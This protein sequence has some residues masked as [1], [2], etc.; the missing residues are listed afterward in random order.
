MS[1]RESPS[2]TSERG[3]GEQRRA[4]CR[5]HRSHFCPCVAPRIYR[6]PFTEHDEVASASE[7]WEEW[8]EEE[9][10]AKERSA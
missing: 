6:P 9:R 4:L 10:Q 5:R 1:E 2:K 7:K 3:V 8:P